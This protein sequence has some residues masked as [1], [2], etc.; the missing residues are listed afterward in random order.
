MSSCVA[1][2]LS[3]GVQPQGVGGNFEGKPFTFPLKQLQDFIRSYEH[4]RCLLSP[5]LEIIL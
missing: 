4:D 1:C 2:S 5:A 3:R